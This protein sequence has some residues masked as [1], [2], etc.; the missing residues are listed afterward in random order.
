MSHIRAMQILRGKR[1][2]WEKR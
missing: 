1:T 2:E